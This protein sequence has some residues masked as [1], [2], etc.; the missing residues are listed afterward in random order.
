MFLLGVDDTPSDEER[1]QCASVFALSTISEYPEYPQL[2]GDPKMD[3]QLNHGKIFRC[4][5]DLPG[6]VT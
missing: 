4:R 6:G 1:N 5:Q 2:R 3:N